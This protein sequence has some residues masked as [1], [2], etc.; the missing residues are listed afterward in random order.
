MMGK[1]NKGLDISIESDK[2]RLQSINKRDKFE[3]CRCKNQTFILYEVSDFP[4]FDCICSQCGC[5]HIRR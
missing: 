5:L 2:K 4:F 1:I 3:C